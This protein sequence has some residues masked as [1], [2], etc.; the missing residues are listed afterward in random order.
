MAE[1][2][3]LPWHRIIRAD[4]FIALE[5]CEG[6]ELQTQLLKDEGVAVSKFG[7]VD[8]AVYG[9]KSRGTP[10]APKKSARKPRR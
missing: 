7:W 2:H 5:S 10:A 4:G 1:K 3:A 6:R 9:V 8:L